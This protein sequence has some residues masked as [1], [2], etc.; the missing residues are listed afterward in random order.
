MDDFEEA[1]A[2]TAPSPI[3]TEHK[4]PDRKVP[5][6]ASGAPPLAIVPRDISEVWRIATILH[7]SR[8]APAGF[9]TPQQITIAIMTGAEVGLPPM[10]ALQSIAI[11]HNRP[12]LWGD[13]LPGVARASGRC[14]DIREWF[15]GESMQ[16]DWTAHCAT[17]RRGAREPIEQSFSVADA[18]LAGLWAKGS[19]SAWAKYPRRML[20]M[21]ARSWCL[22]DAYADVFRGLRAVEE[23]RDAPAEEIETVGVNA[24][25]TP[26]HVAEEP[27][28]PFVEEPV[29]S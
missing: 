20:R 29:T 28:T 22:R 27:G 11:I 9:R 21:R 23:M 15:T 16:D 8:M 13:A 25:A 14:L 19:D 3:E 10:A 7:E 5:L 26:E 1:P 4:E 18:K 17:L 12:C 6:I 24:L 2:E